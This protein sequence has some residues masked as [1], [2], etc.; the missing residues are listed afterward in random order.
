M[1]D[2]HALTLEIRTGP[3][4]VHLDSI[5]AGTL[6]SKA[7]LPAPAGGRDSGASHLTIFARI[8]AT[9][10]AGHFRLKTGQA[11][12]DHGTIGRFGDGADLVLDHVDLQIDEEIRVV[13]RIARR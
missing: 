3:P 11:C 1:L 12:I 5:D 6:L 10:T 2:Q 7:E 8:V 9:G 4:P 13:P